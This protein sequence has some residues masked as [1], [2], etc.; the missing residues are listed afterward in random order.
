MSTIVPYKV[1]LGEYIVSLR[2]T[3]T[4]SSSYQKYYTWLS[5]AEPKGV[6]SE[7]CTLKS[8]ARP[9]EGGPHPEGLLLGRHLR[10]LAEG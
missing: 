2:F 7:R 5:Y 8:R 3:L 9:S 10:N 4:W 6:A 1:D